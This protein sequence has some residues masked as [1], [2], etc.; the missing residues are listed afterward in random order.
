MKANRIS[1]RRNV[2]SCRILLVFASIVLISSCSDNNNKGYEKESPVVN[3][4]PTFPNTIVIKKFKEVTFDF[5]SQKNNEGL[6]ASCFAEL[7]DGK[8]Y[9]V[10]MYDMKSV[11]GTLGWRVDHYLPFGPVIP[12]PHPQGIAYRPDSA[13]VKR[14]VF[15]LRGMK[16]N[17]DISK[18]RIFEHPSQDWSNPVKIPVIESLP[19]CADSSRTKDYPSYLSETFD[20]VGE[21]TVY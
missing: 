7:A 15:L 1:G 12:I 2:K 3:K 13:E 9:S 11:G 10:I 6:Q 4:Y 21:L 19:F 17:A 8:M 18:W 20:L 5:S 14:V 16:D